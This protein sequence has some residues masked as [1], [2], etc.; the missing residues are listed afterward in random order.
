MIAARQI[1]F[2]RGGKRKPYDAEIEYLESTGT[3]Y[4]DLGLNSTIDKFCDFDIVFRKTNVSN[5]VG[6]PGNDAPLSYRYANTARYGIWGRTSAS[7]T[8]GVLWVGVNNTNS[9]QMPKDTEW[10]SVKL[11]NGQYIEIDGAQTPVASGT[12]RKNINLLLFAVVVSA[13]GSSLFRVVSSEVASVKIWNTDGI[14]IRDLIPVRK[15]NIGYMYDRVSG[16]LF[17]NQGTGEFVLGDDL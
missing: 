8:N 16:Q 15:G 2:G 4:I 17:G 11:R 10:H 7:D 6:D 13:S 12:V 3:Q 1:A 14:L 9:V 5:N